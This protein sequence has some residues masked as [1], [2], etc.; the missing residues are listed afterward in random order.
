MYGQLPNCPQELSIFLSLVKL[1]GFESLLA[2][3]ANTL[4]VFA[5]INSV[6]S[7]CPWDGGHGHEGGGRAPSHG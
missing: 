7:S 3:P 5:P 1:A 4:T 2:D 6:R